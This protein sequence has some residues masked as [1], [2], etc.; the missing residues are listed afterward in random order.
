MALKRPK[1]PAGTLVASRGLMEGPHSS[2][3]D[4]MPVEIK[5]RYDSVNQGVA[6]DL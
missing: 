1:D 6:L 4:R 2:V 3:K 5:T